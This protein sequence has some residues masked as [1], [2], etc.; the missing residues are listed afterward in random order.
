MASR[1]F[2]REEE[3]D[4]DGRWS[5]C[6]FSSVVTADGVSCSGPPPRRSGAKRDD[7]DKF[8]V[9]DGAEECKSE[10]VTCWFFRL[11]LLREGDFRRS[12]RSS[13][14]GMSTTPA[15]SRECKLPGGDVCCVFSGLSPTARVGS[16][17]EDDDPL[18]RFP[19]TGLT[20][21]RGLRPDLEGVKQGSL[22]VFCVSLR[23]RCRDDDFRTV[24]SLGKKRAFSDS[25][26]LVRPGGERFETTSSPAASCMESLLMVLVIVDRGVDFFARGADVVP[27]FDEDA[28]FFL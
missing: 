23:R 19:F 21:R 28:C 11:L 14:N 12:V 22:F 13:T 26:L 7:D 4:D 17:D 27:F 8:I 20:F 15:S 9:N 10:D 6:V 25:L 5:C 24:G 18:T 3:E 2:F 1:T 16:P